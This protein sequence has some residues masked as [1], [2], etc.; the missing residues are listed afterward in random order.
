MCHFRYGEYQSLNME[1]ITSTVPYVLLDNL[2]P[3]TDYEIIVKIIIP[4]GIESAWTVRE[5]IRT[6]INSRQFLNF[7]LL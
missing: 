2:Q 1:K 7:I 5:I 4:N 3:A 6:P